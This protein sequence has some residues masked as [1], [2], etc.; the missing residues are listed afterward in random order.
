MTVTKLGY[1]KHQPISVYEDNQP[2][3][4]FLRNNTDNSKTKHINVNSLLQDLLLRY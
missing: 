4:Y 2:A 1:T 3:V